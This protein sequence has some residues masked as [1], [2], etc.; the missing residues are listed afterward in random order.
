MET[1]WAEAIRKKLCINLDYKPGMRVVE[2]H[3]YGHTKDGHLAVRAYQT[4]GESASGEHANWKFFRVD[5]MTSAS[6]SGSTFDGPRPG[7]KR[8]DRSLKG[9]IIAEL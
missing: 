3:A 4:E 9:G 2:P 7:Y 8:G 1:D 6:P 5:R